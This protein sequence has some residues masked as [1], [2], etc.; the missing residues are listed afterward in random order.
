MQ[1][2]LDRAEGRSVVARVTLTGRGELNR[3][4][5]QPN[6]VDHHPGRRQRAMGW[7]AA[8]CVV[9]THRRRNRRSHR[10]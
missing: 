6:A 4:L 8:V 9:R 10:P 2:L 3:F 1:S 7:T 5:R